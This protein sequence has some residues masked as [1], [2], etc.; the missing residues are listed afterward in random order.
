MNKDKW[1][2]L[3]PAYQK[4]IEESLDEVRA[5]LRGQL[6]SLDSDSEQTMVNA[7]VEVIEYDQSF[8]DEVLKLEGVQ[9]LYSDISS[10]TNGLSDTLI[11][12]L[13]KAE[14]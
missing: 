13:A 9:K 6:D 11:S 10:Q 5:D 14:S 1:D 4:A 8:F 12:A 3:D 7:G 2:S